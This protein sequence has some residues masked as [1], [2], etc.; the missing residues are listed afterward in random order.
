MRDELFLLPE[1]L[2]VLKEALCVFFFSL[3]NLIC[4]LKVCL[5]PGDERQLDRDLFL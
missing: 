4:S 2:R 5:E 1:V 3:L